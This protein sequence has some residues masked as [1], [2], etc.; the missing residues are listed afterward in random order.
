MLVTLFKK[1]VDLKR[2]SNPGISKN[3]VF[4]KHFQTLASVDKIQVFIKQDEEKMFCDLSKK[5]RTYYS[6][7]LALF[8]G[9]VFFYKPEAHAKYGA[10]KIRETWNKY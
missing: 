8:E 9:N 5:N 10:N 7:K 2:D 4:T 6:F 1:V 3:A